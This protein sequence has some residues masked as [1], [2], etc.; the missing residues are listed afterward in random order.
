MKFTTTLF[1]LSFAAFAYADIQAGAPG[2]A[3]VT[4]NSEHD[5]RGNYNGEFS[6]GCLELVDDCLSTLNTTQS[7]NIWGV[8]TCVAAA[9]CDGTINSLILAEC[10]NKDINSDGASAPNLDYSLY[11]DIVGSCAW[12][13]G[14]CSMTRQNFIDFIYGCL[15]S[16]NASDYPSPDQVINNWWAALTSWTGTGETIPYL[17][18]NDW[19]HFSHSQ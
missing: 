7:S 8:S 13:E 9:A 1:A 4:C 18:F 10:Q 15:S 14:G 2:D 17:N 6:Q 12:Q 19:L 5:S 16:I 11:A 3:Q